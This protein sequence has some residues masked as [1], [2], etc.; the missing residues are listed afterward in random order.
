MKIAIFTTVFVGL[1][2]IVL[3][4][5]VPL[6]RTAYLILRVQP[7]TQSPS[8]S[9]VALH[10]LGDSTGYGTGASH[11]VY[12]VAGRIGTAYRAVAITNDSVNG[13]TLAEG[14]AALRETE[15][16]GEILLMQLGGNDMLG[17]ESVTAVES[18]VRELLQSATESYQHVVW[19]AAG[20]VGGT[21]RFSGVEAEEYQKRSQAFDAMF[22]N[23][24]SEYGV[25]FVSLFELPTDD[26]F[27]LYPDTFL[28]ADGLHPSNDGYEYWYQKL[29]PTLTLVLSDYGS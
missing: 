16:A 13:R 7:Y 9:V 22:K 11:S 8:E 18:S 5:T 2:V 25:A 3:W 4:Q 17:T 27:V 21:K 1:L 29:S 19:I 20:N 24:A 15:Q 10:V 28:S 26:P 23:V 12:S 14:L 6:L